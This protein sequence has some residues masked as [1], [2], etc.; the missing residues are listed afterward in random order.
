MYISAAPKKSEWGP[1][2]LII[3]QQNGGVL[4]RTIDKLP[5]ELLSEVFLLLRDLYAEG[6]SV[7]RPAPF[8][9]LY[10][11]VPQIMLVSRHWQSVALGCAQLWSYVDAGSPFYSQLL[12]GPKHALL[13]LSGKQ[14]WPESPLLG[15]HQTE[16]AR[17]KSFE[18]SHYD[19]WE[20][21]FENCPPLLSLRDL[22]LQCRSSIYG[23]SDGYNLPPIFVDGSFP[24]LRSVQLTGYNFHWT[25]SVFSV[26]LRILNLR[27]RGPEDAY[28][29]YLDRKREIRTRPTP[30]PF[31]DTL[32]ALQQMPLLE[33]LGLRSIIDPD[34]DRSV[35]VPTVNLAHLK[36]ISISSTVFVCTGLLRALEFPGSAN[37][38]VTTFIPD[39]APYGSA[40]RPL[41]VLFKN[42]GD[43]LSKPDLACSVP[44]I[45]SIMATVAQSNELSKPPR[46]EFREDFVF[47]F[48]REDRPL[49]EDAKTM[50]PFIG[51]FGRIEL[52][53]SSQCTWDP[54]G[55]P[56][57]RI[58]V[59]NE[60]QDSIRWD[61]HFATFCRNW[62][63]G[64]VRT[65]FVPAGA[66][67]FTT[68]T[69][70]AICPDI[71]TLMFRV[72]PKKRRSYYGYGGSDPADSIRESMVALGTTIANDGTVRK[73]KVQRP[74]LTKVERIMITPD[75][76]DW[77]LGRDLKRRT[78]ELGMAAYQPQAGL[79]MFDI[80][81]TDEL[82]ARQKAEEARKALLE[83]TLQEAACSS[84]GI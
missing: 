80:K 46:E 17:V 25:S 44:P 15:Q 71:T 51:Y 77:D 35:D 28:F 19:T 22:S 69:I 74:Q 40:A 48:L 50:D 5:D 49:G 75:P 30:V 11:W 61:G 63:L 24:A 56:G 79:W 27:G 38:D 47:R 20:S 43:K 66:H 10:Q 31:R 78:Q 13:T 12:S 9:R 18:I 68:P 14:D 3:R 34:S 67:R 62:P 37:I 60:A 21:P 1:T 72:P 41:R 4:T 23:G 42:I 64:D 6:H 84:A 76:E 33:Y 52:T 55:V 82:R 16:L 7:L 53:E 8:K 58:C 73:P 45:R 70:H 36:Y 81:K 65:C 59:I 26:N 54:L 2:T 83:K 39:T 29:G 57:A 32:A